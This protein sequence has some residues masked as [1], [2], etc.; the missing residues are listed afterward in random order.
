MNEILFRV[1]KKGGA[2][3]EK[4]LVDRIDE[5]DSRWPKLAESTIK[6]KGSSKA[7]VN[8]SELR[9]LITHKVT[10]GQNGVRVEAGVFNHTKGDI[11]QILEYGTLDGS[12][13]A[14]PLFRPVF[15]ENIQ[16]LE[17]KVKIWLTAEL[18]KK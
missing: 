1:G 4:K 12:I 3:L 15:D 17:Q 6:A 13:P 16:A 14:R 8:T 7:W 10:I 18:L 11:A 2:E 9:G 5:Q